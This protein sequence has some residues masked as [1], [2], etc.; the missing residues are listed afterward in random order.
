M[1]IARFTTRVDPAVTSRMMRA[2]SG[3]ASKPAARRWRDW[4]IPAAHSRKRATASMIARVSAH[5]FVSG[6]P[7]GAPLPPV[8]KTTT[9]APARTINGH[10][11]SAGIAPTGGPGT[12][13]SART[14]CISQAST[15]APP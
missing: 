5:T 15:F 2:A 1:A 13:R 4:H 9:P 11:L 8:R 6:P 3:E 10:P 12:S 7:S 14:P